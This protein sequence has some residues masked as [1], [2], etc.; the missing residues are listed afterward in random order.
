MSVILPVGIC[1]ERD[2]GEEGGGVGGALGGLRGNGF[3]I[4][5]GC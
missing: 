3:G 5:G 2:G 4:V 1:A